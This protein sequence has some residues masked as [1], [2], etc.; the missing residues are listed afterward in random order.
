MEL[1][2]STRPYVNDRD[3]PLVELTIEV[4][5]LPIKDAMC[6]ANAVQLLG[7]QLLKILKE[8]NLV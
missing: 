2:D 1:L 8:R 3:E 5:L 6:E 4:P 7:Q